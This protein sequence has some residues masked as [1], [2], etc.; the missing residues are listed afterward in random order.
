MRRIAR[1]VQEGH[2]TPET[3]RKPRSRS[4]SLYADMPDPDLLIRTAGEMRVKQFPASGRI[5]YARSGSRKTVGPTSVNIIAR[6]IRAYAGRE[7]RF[8][9]LLQGTLQDPA[10]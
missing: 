7:R 10:P 6:A 4:I 2:L 3:R 5:S 8:G 1:G 9:G